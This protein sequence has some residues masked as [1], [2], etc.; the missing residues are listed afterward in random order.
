MGEAQRNP[1]LHCGG[2]DRGIRHPIPTHVTIPGGN[3]ARP[4][5]RHCK[6]TKAGGLIAGCGIAK[7]EPF[8]P[9]QHLTSP[10]AQ[11]DLLNDALSSADDAPPHRVMLK[12]RNDRMARGVFPI[13]RAFPASSRTNARARSGCESAPNWDPS[14]IPG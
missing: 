12:S 10:D 2:T 9:A 6:G 14:A 4:T 1:R 11:T 13:C 8:N 5:A 7:T 3:Q